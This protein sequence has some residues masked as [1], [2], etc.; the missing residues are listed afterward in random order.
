VISESDIA[1]LPVKDVITKPD[2][3]RV[4]I[5]YKTEGIKFQS[6]GDWY[7]IIDYAYFLLDEKIVGKIDINGIYDRFGKQ[8]YQNKSYHQFIGISSDLLEY[9]GSP[10][11][12]YREDKNLI[13]GNTATVIQ[14]DQKTSTIRLLDY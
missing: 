6:E 12:V 10:S 1:G 14:F 7:F 3:I 11:Y 5:A 13:I 2:G 4:K 8:I 9:P